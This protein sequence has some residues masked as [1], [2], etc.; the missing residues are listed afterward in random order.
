MIWI[1]IYLVFGMAGLV[2]IEFEK[3][4]IEVTPGFILAAI[5][6]VVLWPAFLLAVFFESEWADRHLFTIGKHHDNQD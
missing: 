3:Q 6:L 4:P 2:L 1:G 5:L